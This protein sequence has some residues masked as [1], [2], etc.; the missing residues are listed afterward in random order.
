MPPNDKAKLANHKCTECPDDEKIYSSEALRRHKWNIHKSLITVSIN[1]KNTCVKRLENS[2]QCPANLCRKVYKTTQRFSEHIKTH[3]GTIHSTS[4]SSSNTEPIALGLSGAASAQLAVPSLGAPQPF[5]TLRTSEALPYLQPVG[6]LEAAHKNVELLDTYHA[7]SGRQTR[8]VYVANDQSTSTGI[9]IEEAELPTSLSDRET[10]PASTSTVTED[11]GVQ[12]S[13]KDISHVSPTGTP[14]F[15]KDQFVK[16]FLEMDDSQKWML[17]CS[18]RYVEDCLYQF[19]TRCDHEHLCHSFIID[20]E[21]K[22]YLQHQVF[23]EEE[24]NEIRNYQQKQLPKPPKRLVDFLLTFRVRNCQDLRKAAR[25]AWDWLPDQYV[26]ERD[27]DI[28]WARRV[29]D[30]LLSEYEKDTLKDKHLERY[31]DNLW[32]GIIDSCFYDLEGVQPVRGESASIASA[33]RKNLGRTTPGLE[34]LKR[35]KMGRRPEF[36]IRKG[37]LEFACG[38]TGRTEIDEKGTKAIKEGGLKLPKMAKDML[39]ALLKAAKRKEA[40]KKLV[41]VY[42]LHSGPAVTMTQMDSPAGYI[43]RVRRSESYTIP[44]SVTGFDDVLRILVLMWK[45]KEIVRQCIE[46]VEGEGAA[47]GEEVDL[48]SVGERYCNE[49]G[50]VAYLPPCQESPEK[51]DLGKKRP[52]EETTQQQVRKRRG[53]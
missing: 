19:G 32:K 52:V 3:G 10:N 41:I 7:E 38:E 17:S 2:F 53:S 43:C 44:A 34:A 20:R 5:N 11:N 47:L 22:S 26:K 15:L 28:D 46:A 23:S 36:V 8:Q 13:E 9:D 39:T 30:N 4:E 27:F 31:Y 16:R 14:V 51:A 6:I 35:R 40:L 24:L 50:V 12:S 45:G 18:K 42:F 33:C 49:D 21:D 29:C 48:W 25:E 37:Q 1:G